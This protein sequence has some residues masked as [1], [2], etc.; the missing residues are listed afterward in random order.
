MQS[1]KVKKQQLPPATP[2]YYSL[3]EL[4]VP[5]EAL[6]L[7]GECKG[8]FPS[9]SLADQPRSEG[10]KT[11]II[12]VAHN[13]MMITNEGSTA[14]PVYKVMEYRQVNGGFDVY[15]WYFSDQ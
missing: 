15:R 10:C 14:I 1:C 3:A 4:E 9:F 12:D 7:P 13:F 11:S 8:W 2:F 6:P 5:Q